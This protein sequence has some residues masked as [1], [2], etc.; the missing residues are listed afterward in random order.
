VSVLRS[1]AKT[2][3]KNIVP[4]S[5]SFQN[6]LLQDDASKVREIV[7][8]ALCRGAFVCS[9]WE[10]YIHTDRRSGFLQNRAIKH[11]I[12][13]IFRHDFLT[14]PQARKLAKDY[15]QPLRPATVAFAVTVILHN[16]H[17]HQSGTRVDIQF[18]RDNYL[19]EY[20]DLYQLITSW[21][22]RRGNQWDALSD[23]LGLAAL[24][25]MGVN[26]GSNGSGSNKYALLDTD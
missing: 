7:Q 22:E 16:L 23:E 3:A 8:A 2:A 17:E 1:A 14:S 20:K 12:T 24:E 6:Y 11:V 5:Y 18:A 9:D 15:F 25:A 4:T 19:D 13:Q 10:D 21:I 26:F